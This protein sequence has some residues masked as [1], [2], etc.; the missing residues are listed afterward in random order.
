MIRARSAN[1]P[2]PRSVLRALPLFLLCLGVCLGAALLSGCASSQAA[3]PAP[4]RASE[5]VPEAEGAAAS[6]SGPPSDPQASAPTASTPDSSGSPG[7]TAATEAEAAESQDGDGDA[8]EETDRPEASDPPEEPE[9]PGRIVLK[10]VYDDRRV[11]SEQ[12]SV[13]EA[14]LGLYEDPALEDYLRSVAVRLLRHTRTRPFDYTF[15]IVDQE[16]PNAFALPGGKIYVSR[17]LLALVGS[18]AELAAVLGHEI[19]HAAE[20]H[21][22]GRIEHS[23]RINPFTI[24]LRRAAAIAAYGRDQERDADRGGQILSAKAGYD[25]GAI[26][27][28]MRK[29][30]AYDRYEIGW[31]RLPSF[32]ATHPTSPERSAL[33]ASRATS[34]DWEPAEP[35]APDPVLGYLGMIEGL[36]L[37]ANP[38]AGVFEDSRFLHPDLRFSVRFPRGWTTL[39]NPQAVVA[40]SP[41][42]DAQASLTVEG[43]AGD[44]DRVIDEFIESGADGLEVRVQ[45]R[46]P[47]QVRSL[48]GVRIEGKASSGG[49]G[50]WAQMTFVEHGGLVYRLSLLSRSGRA[51]VYRGRAHAFAHSFRPLDE[52][53]AR[54][55]EVTRLRVAR[56]LE[57]ETLEQ[58]S[59]RTRNALEL[60]YTG[61]LNDLFASTT[62][63]KGTPVKIGLREPYIP[64]D[65]EIPADPE[66]ATPSSGGAAEERGEDRAPPLPREGAPRIEERPSGIRPLPAGSSARY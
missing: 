12:E 40:I 2:T 45:D 31:S 6:R 9:Q 7:R 41:E 28:F 24:G 23:R 13:I 17:G 49:V 33:A 25:P 39:N 19:T 58:L 18:E 35:V 4:A 44:L 63:S 56:A 30:D 51:D 27:T 8:A 34:L 46:Q 47:I 62:L 20:R 55:L 61:V 42:R 48:P 66:S 59:A 38:A 11:G 36:V 14:E 21:A 22:A 57:R 60:V 3:P 53:A 52:E 29:L 15:R 26:A 54:S 43:R 1:P 65:P 50:L 10:T 32:L 37:G 64:G 16:V 5:K